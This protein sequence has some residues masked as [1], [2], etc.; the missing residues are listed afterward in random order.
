V[1]EDALLEAWDL[2]STTL[3]PESKATRHTVLLLVALYTRT[4]RP[5]EA[6]EWRAALER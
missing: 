3:G 4:N 2:Q 1:A 5:D 6:D